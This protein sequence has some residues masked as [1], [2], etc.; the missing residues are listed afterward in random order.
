MDGRN[1]L[2]PAGYDIGW[3]VIAAIVVALTVVALILLARSA[4]RLT[5]TQALMW[6]LLILFVPVLGAVAWLAIGRRTDALAS[7]IQS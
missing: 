5:M 4:G 1:P 2:I 3:L 6:V 7:R